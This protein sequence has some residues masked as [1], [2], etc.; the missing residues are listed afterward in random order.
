MLTCDPLSFA[1]LL[2]PLVEYFHASMIKI[3]YTHIYMLTSTPRVTQNLPSIHQKINAPKFKEISLLVFMQKEKGV[4]EKKS[5]CSR[6]IEKNVLRSMTPSKIKARGESQ[7]QECLENTQNIQRTCTSRSSCM[8]SFFLDPVFGATTSCG[9]IES[10]LSY[11]KL[12]IHVT[13]VGSW[14][15]LKAFSEVTNTTWVIEGTIRG[16]LSFFAKFSKKLRD[17]IQ[18]RRG[19]RDAKSKPILLFNLRRKVD[20]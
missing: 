19:V 11:P 9:T 12:H 4:I 15:L 5:I 10:L 18:K 13:E 3:T 20:S 6:S 17:R 1:K 7:R 2:W 16:T 14:G 8:T